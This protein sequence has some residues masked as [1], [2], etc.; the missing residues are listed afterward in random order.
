MEVKL[1][2]T[3]LSKEQQWRNHIEAC[4]SS[5]MSATA[6]CKANDVVAHQYH[7]WKRKFKAAESNPANN[8]PEW[9]P[10]ITEIHQAGQPRHTPILLKVGDYKLELTQGFDKQALLELMK[11]LGSLC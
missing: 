5:G 10:L 1:F 7:Y 8:L 6:W 3:E 2:M 11:L 9:A 4:T